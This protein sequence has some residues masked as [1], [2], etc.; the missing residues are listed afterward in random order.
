MVLTVVPGYSTFTVTNLN[1]SGSGSLRQAVLNANSAAT[2][3]F[4]NQIVFAN[5][6]TGTITLTSS[7][8]SITNSVN[9]IG[10]GA[11]NLTV[12]GNNADRVFNIPASTT[13]SI[14]GLTIA[15]GNV[16]ENSSD[17]TTGGGIQNAGNLTLTN[18]TVS[19]CHADSN[20]G[21]V[22]STGTLTIGSSTFTLN[23]VSFY[24][25]GAINA[26]NFTITNSSITHNTSYAGGGIAGGDPVSTITNSDISYNTGSGSGGGS[27]GGGLAISPGV[28][29]TNSTITHNSTNSQGGG[30]NFYGGVGYAG[31]ISS[32]TITIVG[33]TISNNT[34][35]SDGAGIWN[36][37]YYASTIYLTNSTVANNTSQG[38][39]GGI[40]SGLYATE[41]IN[42]C[43]LSGNKAASGGG[44]YN[45][46]NGT[47]A[48]STVDL[49][50]TTLTGN[51]STGS[52]P[53]LYNVGTATLSGRN[54]ADTAFVNDTGG[55]LQGTGTF[56]GNLINSGTVFPGNNS[57][58][59]TLTIAGNYTQ[60]SGGALDIDFSGNK[61]DIDYNQLVVN[62]TVTL[63]GAL[64]VSL[65]N[66]IV[67]GDSLSF[68]I[69]VN[70]S[71]GPVAGTFAGLSE[72]AIFTVGSEVF[73]ITY[74]AA[75]GNDVVVT[76]V[77]LS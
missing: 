20:G 9:V 54:S 61:S 22:S 44:I 68:F 36:D 17:G 2:Q 37:G 6:L 74:T 51:T 43:T 34:S 69:L 10:P 29:I 30:I 31:S 8:L 60:T 53:G 77:V 3:V 24:T 62:G 35:A 14:S 57:S 45:S 11:A 4:T 39:G 41:V 76:T 58:A 18:V 15:N 71:T 72:G 23:T 27:G 40:F 33:S 73:Q 7:Q 48:F 66:G 56:S 19:N 16:T 28:M 55:T 25:G 42:G 70:G 50:A 67:L 65:L 32:N 26:S 64:N 63:A 59:F 12:S 52:G 13:V 5:G 38:N 1:D 21:G 49:T 75:T 46:G 47:N